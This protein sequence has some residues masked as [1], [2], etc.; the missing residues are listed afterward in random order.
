MVTGVGG[1]MFLCAHIPVVEVRNIESECVAAPV[2]ALGVNDVLE[3]QKNLT[4]VTQIHV[5]VNVKAVVLK[6]LEDSQKRL[7]NCAY[8]FHNDIVYS[9]VTV[10]APNG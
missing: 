5:Q 7:H 1:R 6:H 3:T 2:R 8:L 4:N 9:C 10:L